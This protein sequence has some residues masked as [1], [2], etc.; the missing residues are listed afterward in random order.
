MHVGK[1]E[2]GQKAGHTQINTCSNLPGAPVPSW[3]AAT[4]G[5]CQGNLPSPGGEG[6]DRRSGVCPREMTCEIAR[7]VIKLSQRSAEYRER[8]RSAF[9]K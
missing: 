4:A 2:G 7:A 1:A 3:A 6:W 8:L 5:T 9:A